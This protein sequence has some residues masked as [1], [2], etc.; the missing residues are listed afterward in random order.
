MGGAPESVQMQRFFFNFVFIKP[1][2][3]QNPNIGTCLIQ[4]MCWVLVC[5]FQYEGNDRGADTS[6]SRS[7]ESKDSL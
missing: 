1:H 6:P 2:E 7:T 5:G 4:L 3:L